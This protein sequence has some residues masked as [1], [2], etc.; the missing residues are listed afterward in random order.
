MTIPF[1]GTAPVIGQPSG[2]VQLSVTIDNTD[3]GDREVYPVWSS[4]VLGSGAPAS[5]ETGLVLS[6]PTGSAGDRYPVIGL[7]G[8]VADLGTGITATIN[9]LRQAFQIQRL[10]ERDARGGTRYT[11]ILNAHFNVQSPDSRLQRAEYLGGGSQVFQTRPVEQT[12]STNSTSPQGNLAAYGVSSGSGHSF[13]HSFVEHGYVIGLMC[14]VPDLTYSQG[15]NRMW[16]RET[17]FDFYWPAL[18]HLGEQAVFSREI[19][20][21]GSPSDDSVFGYQ[22]RWAEYRYRPSSLTGLMRPSSDSSPDSTLSFW[23]YSQFFSARPALNLNFLGYETPLSRVLSVPPSTAP[24][25]IADIHI[26]LICTRPMPLYS[27]PGLIDH[28]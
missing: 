25:F 18:A 1:S 10:F 8:L 20:A 9:E 22:E 19:Y 7:Q 5:S 26:N 27:V 11:E 4:G 12:S 16:S 14:V 21:L 17:R 15:L 23:N 28:F 13:S 24:S 2:A 3:T 6:P